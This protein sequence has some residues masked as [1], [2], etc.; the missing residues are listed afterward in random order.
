MTGFATVE[1][2]VQAMRSGAYDYLSKPFNLEDLRLTMQRAAAHF[3][4]AEEPSGVASAVFE[5]APVVVYDLAEATG[6]NRQ[7]VNE[8]GV[9]VRVVVNVLGV[10]V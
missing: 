9:S 10:N 6:L 7:L 3:N 1:A 4:L 2:A 8:V 5:A